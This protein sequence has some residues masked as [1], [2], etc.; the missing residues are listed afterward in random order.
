MTP[1][2]SV[3]RKGTLAHSHLP[4]CSQ[5]QETGWRR[6]TR[7]GIRRPG[8]STQLC[9]PR[10]LLQETSDTSQVSGTVVGPVET[11]RSGTAKTSGAGCSLPRAPCTGGRRARGT[12]DTA[13]RA[14]PPLH[15]PGTGSISSCKFSQN[16]GFY[17]V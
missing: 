9:P 12:Q 4:C 2:C 11:V 6:G 7:G 10:N 16:N 1:C 5:E 13:G 14:W 15:R 17:E 8:L 3:T